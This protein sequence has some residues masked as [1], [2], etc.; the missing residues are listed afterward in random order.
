MYTEDAKKTFDVM[1]QGRTTTNYPAALSSI[2]DI[3]IQPFMISWMQYNP[4]DIIKTLDM[5]ILII[6]GTKDLQASV[7]EANSLKD[8]ATDAQLKIIDKM[9][10]VLFVIDGDD[11]ENSKSYNESFRE[12]S[13]EMMLSIVDFIKA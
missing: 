13:Q 5:P 1:R 3:E 8:A 7:E 4:Q 12:I 2:F 9:N 10:H 6:N 11:L